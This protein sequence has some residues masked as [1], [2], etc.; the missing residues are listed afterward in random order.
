MDFF[1]CPDTQ[2]A[3]SILNNP[4]HRKDLKEFHRSSW[5]S[6]SGLGKQG[7]RS[8]FDPT[9]VQGRPRPSSGH[10]AAAPGAEE[11]TSFIK[12]QYGGGEVEGGGGG[13]RGGSLFV[14]ISVDLAK[15]Q[16]NTCTVGF[17]RFEPS[18]LQGRC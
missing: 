14:R 3:H 11:E 9:R 18:I 16:Q 12:E 6:K 7:S 13:G 15:K 2:G 1:S 4:S 17:L 5:N 10:P 8:N